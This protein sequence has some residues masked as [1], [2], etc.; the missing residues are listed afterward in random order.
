M[1]DEARSYTARATIKNLQKREITVICW[2]P[3][4]PDLNPIKS[5]WNKMKDWIQ[6]YYFKKISIFTLKTAVQKA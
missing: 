3:Y 5:L 1:Q 4:L 6:N 2:P